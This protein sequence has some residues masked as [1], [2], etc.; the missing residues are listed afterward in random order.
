[1]NDIHER[2][3]KQEIQRD[4]HGQI[5]TDPLTFGQHHFVEAF[6]GVPPEVGQFRIGGYQVCEKWLKG[7]KGRTLSADDI[8]PETIR[9]MKEID[10]VIEAHGGWP[11]AF[12]TTP[13]E[14]A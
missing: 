11:G 10:D 12:V 1:M 14:T 2:I 13:K 6:V 8:A 3:A 4:V 7:R 5:T 9:L